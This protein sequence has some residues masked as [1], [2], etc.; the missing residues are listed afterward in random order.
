MDFV[1]CITKNDIEYLKA[2]FMSGEEILA[3]DNYDH[4]DNVVQ[5][6]T[7]N[8]MIKYTMFAEEEGNTFYIKHEVFAKPVSYKQE[9]YLLRQKIMVLK[10][11][12]Y[13]DQLKIISLHTKSMSEDQE[14]IEFV[15]MRNKFL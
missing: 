3:I 4:T 6:T 10:H 5:F 13:A 7:G 15:A 8:W 11:Y 2:T 12:A 14:K 9:P 1:K